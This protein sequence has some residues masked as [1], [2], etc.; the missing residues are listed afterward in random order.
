MYYVRFESANVPLVNLHNVP[1][2]TGPNEIQQVLIS[3]KRLEVSP[4]THHSPATPA[5]FDSNQ[6]MHVR[7]LMSRLYAR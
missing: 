5:L 3:R 1:D 7:T 4:L 2:G 6:P